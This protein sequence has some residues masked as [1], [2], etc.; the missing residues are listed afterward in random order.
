M[1]LK[2]IRL[3]DSMQRAMARE[4]K[5]GREKRAKIIAAEGKARG[6]AALGEAPDTTVKHRDLS[7]PAD[8]RDRRTRHLLVPR[9]GRSHLHAS[10]RHQPALRDHAEVIISGRLVRS[11]CRCATW[12]IG[13]SAAR[14]R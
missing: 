9:I 14:R 10:Q 11:A 4:A 3:P 2:D 5:A 13:M 8:E 1:E 7:R 6:A 12:H